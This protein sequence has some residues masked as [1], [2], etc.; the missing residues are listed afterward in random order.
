MMY[1]LCAIFQ[2]I[3]K[4][5]QSSD[6]ILPDIV[7][8]RDAAMRNLV[9]VK[10]MPVPGGKEKHYLQSLELS[11]EENESIRETNNQFVT[12]MRRSNDAVRVE[13][14]Q[15]AINFLSERMNIEEDGT[16]NNLKKYLNQNL[17]RNS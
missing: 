2:R 6:L 7:T 11:G 16:I 3:Q 13:I 17:Q 4:I 15:S 10:E 12:S 14:V 9:I 1:D 5:F 8:A